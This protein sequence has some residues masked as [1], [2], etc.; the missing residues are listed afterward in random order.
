MGKIHTPYLVKL[1]IGMISGDERLF[2]DV[3]KNLVGLYGEIDLRSPVYEWRHTT[4]Y[5]KELGKDLKR[6]FIFFHEPIRADT[7]PDIKIKTNSIEDT[8]SIEGKRRINLDP[9]YITPAKVVLASTKD[10][11]HRIYLRDGIYAEVTLSYHNRTFNPLPY[12]FP[13]FRTDEYISLFN[14]ARNLLK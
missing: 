8:F 11:A 2:R 3:E 13:D 6:Q 10:F 9:G 7:L 1:F 12:T 14:T 5:E 4:Y